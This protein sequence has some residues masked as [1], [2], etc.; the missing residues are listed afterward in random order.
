V[1]RRLR[2]RKSGTL[3][4]VKNHAKPCWSKFAQGERM[5]FLVSMVGSQAVL[6]RVTEPPRFARQGTRVALGSVFSALS[7]YPANAVSLCV[8]PILRTVG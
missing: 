5:P 4:L 2:Q 6:A 1:F 8:V 3:N 7:R